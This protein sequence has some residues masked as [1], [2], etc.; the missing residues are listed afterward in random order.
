MHRCT[1]R[2]DVT[3]GCRTCRGASGR[4]KTRRGT[5]HAAA[6]LADTVGTL[7]ASR[8]RNGLAQG[9]LRL[10]CPDVGASRALTLQWHRRSSTYLTMR[11]DPA[12]TRQ[13]APDDLDASVPPPTTWASSRLART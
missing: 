13:T 3:W 9:D 2:Q 11:P 4:G 5:L 1:V 7:W 12:T 6:D 10:G 8:S